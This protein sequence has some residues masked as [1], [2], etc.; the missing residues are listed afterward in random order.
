VIAVISRSLC[1]WK[2]SSMNPDLLTYTRNPC[3]LTAPSP[4]RRA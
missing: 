2:S 3:K 4:S 1:H